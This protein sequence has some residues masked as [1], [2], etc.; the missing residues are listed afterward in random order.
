[1]LLSIN[2]DFRLYELEK[3][4]NVLLL[5][6]CVEG[7]SSCGRIKPMLRDGLL[8][9]TPEELALTRTC[10]GPNDVRKNYTKQV[11]A[12]AATSRQALVGSCLTSAWHNKPEAGLPLE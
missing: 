2:N 12:L 6:C 9:N 1:M 3:P 8:G 10:P 4:L 7:N 11:K 5:A